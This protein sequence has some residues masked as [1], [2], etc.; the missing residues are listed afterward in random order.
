M[1]SAREHLDS[2][3]FSQAFPREESSSPLHLETVAAA[4]AFAEQGIAVLSDLREKRSIIFYGSLGDTLG[5]AP[6]G[7]VH[8]VDSIWEEELLSRIPEKDLEGKQLLEIRLVDFVGRNGMGWMLDGVLP[9]KDGKGEAHLVRHRIRYFSEGSSIRYALCLYNPAETVVEAVFEDLL[10]GKRV[11]VGNVGTKGI[12]SERELEVLRM[13]DNG[14]SS[15]VIASSLGISIHT[16]SRHRQNILSKF[17]AGN[18]AQA[19]KIAKGLGIL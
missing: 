10:S 12:L 15:K 6:S 3:F 17:R 14:S 13:I 1:P 4:Y 7:A 18:S 5:I 2:T 19:C 9:M 11:P 8:E 16:V